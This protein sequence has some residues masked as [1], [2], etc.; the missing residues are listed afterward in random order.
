MRRDS[1]VRM[2]GAV[3]L[4]TILISKLAQALSSRLTS[5]D[6]SCA[7]LKINPLQK[8]YGK[9]SFSFPMEIHFVFCV[10]GRRFAFN[11]FLRCDTPSS[12]LAT[13]GI[14]AGMSFSAG[15]LDLQRAKA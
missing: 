2:F 6:G 8:L 11:L 3:R 13:V 4:M 9:D 10:K 14:I 12:K 7:V 15:N 1:S 5:Q